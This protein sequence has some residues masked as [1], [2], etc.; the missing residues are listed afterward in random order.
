MQLITTQTDFIHF[1]TYINNI[2][3]NTYMIA[4]CEKPG[5]QKWRRQGGNRQK[6]DHMFCLQCV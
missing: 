1:E 4:N 6:N 2:N 5:F 3:K